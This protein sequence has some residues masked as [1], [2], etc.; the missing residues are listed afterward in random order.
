M[1]IIFKKKL[2]RNG[3]H[4]QAKTNSFPVTNAI[5]FDEE[6]W[7]ENDALVD[8]GEPGVPVKALYDYEGAEN[9]ELSFKQGKIN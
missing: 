7:E 6:E 4:V 5:P 8:T 3:S 9:D 1:N 2:C